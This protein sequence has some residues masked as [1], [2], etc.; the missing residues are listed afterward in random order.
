MVMGFFSSLLLAAT[1][2]CITRQAF[3]LECAVCLPSD[4]NASIAKEIQRLFVDD[5]S[6]LVGC[7]QTI[8]LDESAI[9]K[10]CPSGS[11]S[12]HIQK[13]KEWTAKTCSKISVDDCKTA[14]RVKYCYCKTNRCNMQNHT[15]STTTTGSTMQMTE[16]TT[17]A[18]LSTRPA[19]EQ[20]HT[21]PRLRPKDPA[22]SES[23][24]RQSDCW[25]VLS[26]LLMLYSSIQFFKLG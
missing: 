7:N 17:I 6:T 4:E 5:Q 16:S 22:K 19:D 21:T 25:S 1:T 20:Y 13:T 15:N 14:N 9:V 2:L 24:K 3:G 12:C 8:G 11:L 18:A 10:T 23:K 26:S